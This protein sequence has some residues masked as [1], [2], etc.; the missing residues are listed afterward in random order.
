MD[1]P[2]NLRHLDRGDVF[3]Q[4]ELSVEQLE[5]GDLDE[6]FKA[7]LPLK[8]AIGASK[9]ESGILLRGELEI[10]LSCECARC[11]EPFESV[12]RIEDWG[13]LLPLDGEEAVPVLNDCVDLTPYLR[14]D[15]LLAFPQRPLCRPDCRGTSRAV[16][17]QSTPEAA[18]EPDRPKTDA[19]TWAALD[20][21]NLTK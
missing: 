15:I 2:L 5:F 8:Y 7:E 13:R 17:G 10:P 16:S 11:L 20:K 21:L 9:F 12:V 6:L 4:G 14:E 18:V 1:L 3:L 19:S